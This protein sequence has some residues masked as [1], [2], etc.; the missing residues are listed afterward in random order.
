[1]GMFSC[2]SICKGA[3]STL[4]YSSSVGVIGHSA[5]KWSYSLHLKHLI[6]SLLVLTVELDF[7]LSHPSLDNILVLGLICLSLFLS[8]LLSLELSLL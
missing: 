1:M 2:V 6:W 8:L 7:D 3:G 4:L 5:V